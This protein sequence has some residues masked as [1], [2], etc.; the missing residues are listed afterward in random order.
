MQALEPGWK[1]CALR[2]CEMHCMHIRDDT[3]A[4]PNFLNFTVAT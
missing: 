3:G 1:D 2:A 4:T